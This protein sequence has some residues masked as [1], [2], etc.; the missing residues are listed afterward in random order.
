M[1]N[2]GLGCGSGNK[3]REQ[4][5]LC[6]CAQINTGAEPYCVR[7]RR[8]LEANSALQDHKCYLA[9]PRTLHCKQTP[10]L[11]EPRDFIENYRFSSVLAQP[12]ANALIRSFSGGC[13]R[14]A[15]QPS[16]VLSFGPAP[17]LSADRWRGAILALIGRRQIRS[18]R[19]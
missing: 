9:A 10:E 18:W 1:R 13:C 6:K 16:L 11:L 2:L 8:V 5:K 4:P 12:Q 14:L 19:L 17:L 15:P 3:E 7:A